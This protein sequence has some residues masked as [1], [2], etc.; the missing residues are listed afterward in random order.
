MR[1]NSWLLP[2]AVPMT[3]APFHRASCTAKLPMPPAAPWISTFCPVRSPP[4][5]KSPCHAVSAA[6]GTEAAWTWSIEVG[7]NASSD[8]GTTVNSA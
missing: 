4:T 8:S 5:S 3:W 1:R 7:F 6:I 2:D